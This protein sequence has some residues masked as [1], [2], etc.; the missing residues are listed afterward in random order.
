[1]HTVVARWPHAARGEFL[2]GR[3][4]VEEVNF[5]G[6]AIGLKAATL[7]PPVVEERRWAFSVGAGPGGCECGKSL[8]A[9]IRSEGHKEAKT[10]GGIV[11]YAVVNLMSRLL[12]Q[13]GL[14]CELDPVGGPRFGQSGGRGFLFRVGRNDIWP[15]GTALAIFD[16]NSAG[17][18]YFRQVKGCG[19]TEG[20]ACKGKAA[21][22]N[23]AV[24]VGGFGGLFGGLVDTLVNGLGGHGVLAGQMNALHLHQVEEAG[25]IGVFGDIARGP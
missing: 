3:L 12:E 7:A 25:A 14:Q 10:F 20:Y 17:S 16:R 5:I 9:E 24:G 2:T 11:Y 19:E 1:M 4:S 23:G 13:Q 6:K 8:G 22:G 21:Q 18:L 15:S